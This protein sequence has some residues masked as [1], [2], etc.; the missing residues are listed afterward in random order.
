MGSRFLSRFLKEPLGRPRF[1]TDRTEMKADCW[2]SPWLP[3][4]PGIKRPSWAR[5]ASFLRMFRRRRRSIV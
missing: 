4:A 5:R 3:S 1:L 2:D